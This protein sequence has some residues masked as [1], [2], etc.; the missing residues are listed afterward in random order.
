MLQ[1][2][3]PKVKGL[4]DL[5]GFRP[6]SDRPYSMLTDKTHPWRREHINADGTFGRDLKEWKSDK[7]QEHLKCMT[8]KFLEHE[9]TGE[10]LWPIGNSQKGLLE[11]SKNKAQ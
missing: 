6:G 2:D 11:Y 9:D 3:I 7:V 4:L 8:L 10:Q 1:K 5:L